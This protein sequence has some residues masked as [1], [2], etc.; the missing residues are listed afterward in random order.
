M[1]LVSTPVSVAGNLSGLT[2]KSFAVVSPAFAR[3]LVT[4]PSL[5]RNSTG[6]NTFGPCSSSSG[7]SNSQDIGAF[8]DNG[9]IIVTPAGGG[10]CGVVVDFTTVSGKTHFIAIHV[11]TTRALT[12]RIGLYT[13]G[14]VLVAGTE[15]SW[16]V[17]ANRYVRIFTSFFETTGQARRIGLLRPDNNSD[18]SQF[19]CD[20]ASAETDRLTTYFSGN[21]PSFLKQG[22]RWEGAAHASTSIRL[23]QERSGG[24]VKTFEELGIIVNG[25]QGAGLS[26]VAPSMEVSPLTDSVNTD[27]A[28]RVMRALT[29]LVSLQGETEV[30]LNS[31]RAVIY[32]LF[33]PDKRNPQPT[34]LKCLKF[35]DG[36]PDL[37]AVEIDIPCVYAGGLEGSDVN[38]YLEQAA[39]KFQLADRAGFTVTRE[40]R[41]TMDVT[42]GFTT[43]TLVIRTPFGLVSITAITGGVINDTLITR[44]GV[45]YVTGTFTQI[46]GVANTAGIARITVMPDGTVVVSALGT[47]LTGGAGVCLA[48]DPAGNILV[49]GSFTGAG[50][51]ATTASIARFNMLTG[52]WQRVAAAATNGTVQAIAFLN[53]APGTTIATRIYVGGAGITLIGGVGA[54]FGYAAYNAYTDSNF[55]AGAS[56]TGGNVNS[57]E[58]DQVLRKVYVGGTFTSPVNFFGEFV[59]PSTLQAVVAVPNG[60][61]TDMSINNSVVCVVGFFTTIGGITSNYSALL[62]NG[63]FFVMGQGLTAGVNPDM[64]VSNYKNGFVITGDFTSVVGLPNTRGSALWLGS[65]FASFDYWQASV[66]GASV[67]RHNSDLEYTAYRI[68]LPGTSEAVKVVVVNNLSDS[69]VLRGRILFS[70]AT[71]I[72]WIA[73]LTTGEYIYFRGTTFPAELN[74]SM[75]MLDGALRLIDDSGASQDAEILPG[76]AIQITLLP[77]NNAIAYSGGV[78]TNSVSVYTVWDSLHDTLSEALV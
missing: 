62:R 69:T 32:D 21:S 16:R 51:V 66:V 63:Q 40:G 9:A 20:C 1:S 7:P 5:A 56:I 77:G 43:D 46:S 78:G 47:G 14:N 59:E 55:L 35:V 18:V 6:W 41:Q 2:S 23:P 60:A 37:P 65:S 12:F 74:L 68:R 57:I 67:A 8:K 53:S 72:R 3:N 25:V 73:N 27:P 24:V 10:D 38:P 52:V 22:Y 75:Y 54:N 49:G 76:S 11:L 26:G 39:I 48:E 34:M 15:R 13:T 4:N 36:Y 61:V 44:S 31:L 30:A 42:G 50:G 29:L 28:V 45:I 19:Y 58:T 17:P 64:R 71:G 70:F 33:F